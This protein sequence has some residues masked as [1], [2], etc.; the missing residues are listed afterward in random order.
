MDVARPYRFTW[1]GDIHDPKPHY[2]IGFDGRFFAD[3]GGV[4]S[5]GLVSRYRAC[6]LGWTYRRLRSN[7]RAR[8]HGLIGSGDIHGPAPYEITRSDFEYMVF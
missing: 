6:L 7:R 1:L 4:E 2:F 8:P 5:V 3:T